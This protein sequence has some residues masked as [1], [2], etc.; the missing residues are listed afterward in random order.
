M[1]L[2]ASGSQSCFENDVYFFFHK[3]AS[4]GFGKNKAPGIRPIIILSD[5]E[6]KGLPVV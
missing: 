5:S 1:M 2:Y 4:S 3:T 6:R